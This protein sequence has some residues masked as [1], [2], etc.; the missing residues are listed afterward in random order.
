MPITNNLATSEIYNDASGMNLTK[1]I[2]YTILVINLTLKLQH[3]KLT[4][5]IS[6]SDLSLFEWKI[7]TNFVSVISRRSDLESLGYNLISWLGGKLPW[8]GCTYS[9]VVTEMK[10]DAINN[11]DDFLSNTLSPK[12]VPGTIYYK[13]YNLYNI[14]TLLCPWKTISHCSLNLYCDGCNH[15]II[16]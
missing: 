9:D 4:V 8:E 13:F 11:I 1:L 2:I 16:K 5:I 12:Y 3:F 7:E 14:N 10:D 15:K 6:D